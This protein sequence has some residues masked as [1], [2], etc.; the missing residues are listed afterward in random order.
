MNGHS[1]LQ[2]PKRLN[3]SYNKLFNVVLDFGNQSHPPSGFGSNA[4]SD[5][6]ESRNFRPRNP[7]TVILRIVWSRKSRDKTFI[8]LI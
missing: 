4:L 1:D 6:Y 3:I 5:S 8:D 2:K 7:P